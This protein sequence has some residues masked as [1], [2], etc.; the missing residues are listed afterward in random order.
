MYLTMCRKSLASLLIFSWI[1]L[2]GVD[3]VA[4]FDLSD[5]TQLHDPSD[6][7]VPSKPFAVL[8]GS[9]IDESAD[10]RGI[11]YENP[12]DQFTAATNS[13]APDVPQK[14]SKLYK[15]LRVFII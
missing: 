15:V 13:Y 11:R 1:I 12:V 10:H 3:L 6:A 9:D 2:C 8:L 4:G 7:H 5:S 14:F